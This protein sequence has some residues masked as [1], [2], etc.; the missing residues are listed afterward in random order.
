MTKFTKIPYDIPRNNFTLQFGSSE[1]VTLRPA[2]MHMTYGG[3][4]EG[5]ADLGHF[6]DNIIEI[7]STHPAKDWNRLNS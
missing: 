6:A 2:L 7:K 5:R 3:T 1:K 4:W